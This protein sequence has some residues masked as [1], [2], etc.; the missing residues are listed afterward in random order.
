MK[1]V[2]VLIMKKTIKQ[3]RYEQAVKLA[4][5]R[6]PDCPELAILEAQSIMTSF[7]RLCKL[8]ERNLYLS[9]DANKANLKSTTESEEREQKWFERLNK[10][11]QNKYGLCLCYCG[12]M[13]SIGIRNE[14]GSFTEKIER[15]FYE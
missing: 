9:N 4:S 10:V 3:L 6:D 14:N 8:S 5:Y 13:P 7:Y 1:I 11:F 12:Y 15:Y 2:E